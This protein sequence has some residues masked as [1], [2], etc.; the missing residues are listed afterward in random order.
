MTDRSAGGGVRGRDIH[1]ALIVQMPMCM[2]VFR[3]LEMSV[4][5]VTTALQTWGQ[6]PPLL[7]ALPDV[8]PLIGSQWAVCV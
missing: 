8:R 4:H 7:Y 2:K 1:I 5:C 6:S 3:G